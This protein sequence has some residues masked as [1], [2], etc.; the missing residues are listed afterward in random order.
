MRRLPIIRVENHRDVFALFAAMNA[1]GYNDENRR[2]G[3]SE[4]RNRV[5][6]TLGRNGW[7]RRYPL[8]KQIIKKHHPWYLLSAILSLQKQSPF[9]NKLILQLNRFFNEPKAQESWQIYEIF[10]TKEVKKLTPLFKHEFARLS[11]FL[12]VPVKIKR[13]IFIIN[14]LDAFWRGYSLKMGSTVYVIVGPG[15][16]KNSCELMRHEILHVLAPQIRLPVRLI[17]PA[18]HRNAAALGYRSSSGINREYAVRG[19]NLLYESKILHKDISKAIKNEEK[20]FP[21][22]EEVLTLIQAKQ[23]GRPH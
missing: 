23:K 6:G 20:L 11:A 9:S 18:S 22:I 14:Y 4:I 16:E 21:F 7:G 3:M 10:Q 1:M 15:A 17:A 2:E 19:F 8:L 13:A 12:G 5:R